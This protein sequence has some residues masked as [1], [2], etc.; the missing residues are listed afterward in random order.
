[1]VTSAQEREILKWDGKTTNKQPD[2]WCWIGWKKNSSYINYEIG[3]WIHDVYID[4]TGGSSV[5][6][7][8]RQYLVQSIINILYWMFIT[9]VV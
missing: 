8:G 7:S 6:F 2:V 5:V 4:S 1:M 3:L 9:Y